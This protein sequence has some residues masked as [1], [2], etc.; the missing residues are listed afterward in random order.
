MDKN[1]LVKKLTEFWLTKNEAN[2]YISN[3]ETWNAVVSS[4]SKNSWLNRVT[5]YDILKKLQE[6]W[7]VIK[8]NISWIKYFSAIEPKIFLEEKKEKIK[9]LEESIPFLE[10]MQLKWL[11]NPEIRHF[12]WI[13]W[14]KKAYKETLLSKTNILNYANSENVRQHWANYD[15]EYIK[16]RVGKW[17]FLKWIAPWDNFWKRVKRQ[18]DKFYRKTKLFEKEKFTIENE[19]KIFDNKLLIASFEPRPFAII[20]ESEAVSNTQ[21]Q[22]FEVLWDIL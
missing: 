11:T 3:L 14:I 13:K 18:D 9:S 16:K 6:K 20:I 17:I 21:R 19:I 12:K 1:I 15:E 7:L 2:T 10:K 4:I 8:S 5:T 22:I